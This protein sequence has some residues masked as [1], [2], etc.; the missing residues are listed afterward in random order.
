MNI[1]TKTRYGFRF[2]IYLAMNESQG[3]SIQLGE[4]AEKEDIS[5]KY[6]EKIAQMLKRGGL[7]SV[8]R[9]PKGGYRLSREPRRIT[10]ED[11]FETLEG[12]CSVLDCLDN[13]SCER[14][15]KC[16]SIDIWKG[17]S[18]AIRGFLGSKTLEDIVQDYQTKNH[19]F[20]I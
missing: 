11:I 12:S 17:L 9:G 14:E 7:I 5:L 18:D 20:Y 16:S 3:K 1:S 19:M 13:D 10:L 6:L 15:D 4:V 8:K 2:M